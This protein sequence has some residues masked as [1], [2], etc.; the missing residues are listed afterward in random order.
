MAKHIS[1]AVKDAV[2]ADIK[3]GMK[4]SEASVKHGVTDNTIYSWLKSQA[5]NTG[6]SSLEVARLRRENVELK[7]IIGLFALEKKRAEKN[8]KAS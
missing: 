1:A 2:L 3:N 7:E 4:V 5:D 8:T 6:T